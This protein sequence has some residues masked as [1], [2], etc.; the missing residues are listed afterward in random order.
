AN[1]LIISAMKIFILFPLPILLALL[2]A[3]IRSKGF[4]TFV[5]SMVFLPHFLSW[6]VIVGIFKTLLAVDGPINQILG[7]DLN[8]FADA[9]LFRGLVVALSGWKEIGYSSIVYIA[10]ILSID[11]SLYEAARL[12]GAGKFR[13]MFSVTLPMILPTIITMLIIRLGYLMEAGFEQVYAMISSTTRETG[14]IIG[15]YIYRISLGENAGNYGLSTAVG[16][17]NGVISL[18]LIVTANYFSKKFTQESIW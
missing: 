10:A 18:A 14:E 12:D 15:T 3:D 8:W 11:V 7:L 5:Q 4:S 13:Q 16:L 17:F 6:V 9:K 1:T 2:V